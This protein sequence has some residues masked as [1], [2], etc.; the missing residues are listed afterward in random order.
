MNKVKN[1]GAIVV[2]FLYIGNCTC[3]TL[4]ALAL[5]L[6]MINIQSVSES[7]CTNCTNVA[8]SVQKQKLHLQRIDIKVYSPF[9][10]INAK[11]E[12]ALKLH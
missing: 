7:N 12:I 8:Q 1:I 2:H 3:T 9:S 6:Y 10:T 4:I 5:H 11:H